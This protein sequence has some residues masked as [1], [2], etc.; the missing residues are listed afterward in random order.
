MRY[1]KCKTLTYLT[2]KKCTIQYQFKI[3]L[4]VTLNAIASKIMEEVHLHCFYLLVVM[5]I[6]V[7]LLILNDPVETADSL[8][9][10]AL[11]AD[12]VGCG[13]IV[14]SSFIFKGLS[15]VS[16]FGVAADGVFLSI[17]RLATVLWA[18]Y[19]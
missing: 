16:F 17:T 12:F 8:L 9:V 2:F 10:P 15:N 13:I 4:F 1:K 18:E 7:P 6:L 5:L 19:T 11:V 14:I 3:D